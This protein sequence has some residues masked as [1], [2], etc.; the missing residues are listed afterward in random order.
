M[1]YYPASR[2]LSRLLIFRICLKQ[3]LSTRNEYSFLTES[4]SIKGT[5]IYFVTDMT[6]MLQIR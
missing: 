4:A 3:V 2:V 5:M 1:G 6:S